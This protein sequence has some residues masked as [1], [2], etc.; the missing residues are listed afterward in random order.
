MLVKGIGNL[1]R[2]TDR[3]IINFDFLYQLV[4]LTTGHEVINSFPS[5]S[6]VSLRIEEDYY[7][8]RIL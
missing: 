8:N 2:V 5:L 3:D 1:I 6:R 4:V 7:D